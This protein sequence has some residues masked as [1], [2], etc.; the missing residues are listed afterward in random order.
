MDALTSKTKNIDELSSLEKKLAW[1]SCV[2]CVLLAVV[3][4]Y[5]LW[6]LELHH[7]KHE[8]S[9]KLFKRPQTTVSRSVYSE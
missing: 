2:V 8:K 6:G 4:I 3:G 1:L 7:D 9:D 5:I